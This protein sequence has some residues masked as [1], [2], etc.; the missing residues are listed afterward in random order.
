MWPLL[1]TFP[2]GMHTI[3]DGAFACC[4][5]LFGTVHF[6]ISASFMV[7]AVSNM[8]DRDNWELTTLRK[9]HNVL[10]LILSFQCKPT[11]HIGDRA[12]YHSTG[13][14]F[15]VSDV[16]Q[17]GEATFSG[18]RVSSE[19]DVQLLCSSWSGS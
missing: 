12:F 3:P 11:S 19:R 9:L 4:D 16:I 17:I 6:V 5:C 13:L 14:I 10:K 15:G 1:F 18:C 2:D 8:H 7:W